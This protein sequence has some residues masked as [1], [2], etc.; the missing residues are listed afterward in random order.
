MLP[1]VGSCT[2]STSGHCSFKYFIANFIIRDI[3]LWLTLCK[4]DPQR[5]RADSIVEKRSTRCEQ[6]TE[7]VKNKENAHSRRLTMASLG[8]LAIDVG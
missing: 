3:Y 8:R 6:G 7:K 1:A 4:N 5:R 2:S